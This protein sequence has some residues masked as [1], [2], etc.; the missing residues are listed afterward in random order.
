LTSCDKKPPITPAGGAFESLCDC[1]IDAA[2]YSIG[3]HSVK[4]IIQ[5]PCLNEESHLPDTVSKLPHSITGIDTIELL[6]VD[7]GS[8]DRTSDVARKLGA[9]V[10]RIPTN[11]GLANAF[12]V[13]LEAS[14]ARGASIVVNTDADN[15]YC[16]QD[17]EN[18]VAPILAGRADL[19][20]GARPIS[21]IASFSLQKKVLQF[22]GSW[23]VRILSG[24]RVADASSGFRAISREAALQ[25]NV[26]SRYTY[27][28]ETIVQAAQRGLRV[29]SV[30][31]RV[32]ESTRASRLAASNISYLWRAGSGL[33]RIFVV[34]RPFRSFMVPAVV[35]FSAATVIALRFLYYL[36]DSSGGAGHIQSLIF[37]AILYGLSGVLLAVAFLGDLL[38]INRRLLEEIR[39]D[40]R[41]TKF[42]M[43]HNDPT[44]E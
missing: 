12:M 27:T 19:V 44:D 33:I 23:V 40:M 31:I 14:L 24:T 41:R 36:F 37:A 17:I 26:F 22:I 35:L 16:G 5:I 29:T 11:R 13:G 18:L 25:A 39:L 34:Y 2:D 38:A 1:F 3:R 32:N 7:D 21:K 8:T 10:V 9:L 20:V 6:V 4:L 28:L 30:P 15:Q 43:P 42:A